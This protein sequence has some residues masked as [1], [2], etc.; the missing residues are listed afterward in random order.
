MET[1]F[2]FYQGQTKINITE[3]ESVLNSKLISITDIRV[4]QVLPGICSERKAKKNK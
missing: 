3:N 1:N 2:D 4:C